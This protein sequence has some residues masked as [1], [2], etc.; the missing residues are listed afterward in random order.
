M[1]G[2]DFLGRFTFWGL[3]CYAGLYVWLSDPSKCMSACR[4]EAMWCS[5]DPQCVM[6]VMCNYWGRENDHFLCGETFK[7]ES[8]DNWMECAFVD[9]GCLELDAP[10]DA[11]SAECKDVSA[12]K[13]EVSANDFEGTWYGYFGTHADYDCVDCKQFEF[14]IEDGQV[15]YDAK[16]RLDDYFGTKRINSVHMTG[17]FG[18]DSTMSVEYHD[19][20][21]THTQ[22]WTVIAKEGDAMAMYWCGQS[23]TW[24][25]DGVMILKRASN[26]SGPTKAIDTNIANALMAKVEKATGHTSDDFCELKYSTTCHRQFS[27]HH[28][29]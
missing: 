17:K 29:Y 16:Y 28:N 7:S 13:I 2:S 18:G 3:V 22:Q 5:V 9:A 1:L 8:L 24:Q 25:Y 4:T 10:S 6:G 19:S 23:F 14:T 11:N 15:V 20:G 12:S 21:I 26:I 27:V